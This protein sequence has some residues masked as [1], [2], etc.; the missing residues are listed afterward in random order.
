MSCACIDTA[1]L[2]ENENEKLRVYIKKLEKKIERYQRELLELYSS[3]SGSSS[4]ENSLDTSPVT[5]YRIL[6][7]PTTPRHKPLLY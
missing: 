3:G 4:R 7:V 1:V 5:K 6:Y 2:M